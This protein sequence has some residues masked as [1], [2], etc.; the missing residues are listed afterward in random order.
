MAAAARIGGEGLV[1][2]LESPPPYP[3]SLAGL[4]PLVKAK[5]L[6]YIL[7]VSGFG[8]KRGL[9]SYA[10]AH[11]TDDLAG[12]ADEETIACL[13]R[14]RSLYLELQSLLEGLESEKR[15]MLAARLRSYTRM[16]VERPGDLISI[17]L[18]YGPRDPCKLPR[19]LGELERRIRKHLG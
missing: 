1:A 10:L 8:T 15:R 2:W 12:I 11:G 9:I 3:E 7:E 6:S 19:W 17:I 4:D 13:E 18:R 14:A 5:N 16:A